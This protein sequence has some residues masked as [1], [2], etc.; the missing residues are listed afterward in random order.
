ML[1]IRYLEGASDSPRVGLL[2]DDE[3]R[4]LPGI[5]TI[6][7][8]LRLSL[9]EFNDVLADAS[10]SLPRFSRAEVALLAPIDDK[11]EVWAAG[12]TYVR[13]RDARVVESIAASSVYDQVY[14]AERP[15]LFFKGAAWRV[16]GPDGIGMVRTDSEVDVPE[17]ELAL[18]VNS[19][20]EIVGYSI[21]DDISSRSIEGENPLYLPQAKIFNGSSV[22][23]PGIKPAM[24]VA[25]PYDLE[26]KLRI[27]RSG[28]VVWQGQASTRS[29]H[30]RFTDLV[31][32]LFKSLSFPDG[33][34]LSTGT[35]LVPNL[36]FSLANDDMVEISIAEI[37]SLTHG[38]TRQGS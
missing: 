4:D 35:G 23:G 1:V 29:M 14:E 11:T 30:R 7:Q 3:I 25:D 24:A 10:T 20:G 17:P 6:G 37:G 8:M 33:V 38:I 22:L 28:E 31:S 27:Q 18:V 21:C 26:I 9:S 32:W 19:Y 36:P 16:V 15:E 5:E 34:V 13:S 2:M 12:V